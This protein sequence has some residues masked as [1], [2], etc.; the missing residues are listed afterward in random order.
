[1]ATTVVEKLPEFNSVHRMEI[2]LT[3]EGISEFNCILAKG[4]LDSAS[5]RISS[6]LVLHRP[7]KV[8]ARFILLAPS[9]DFLRNPYGACHSS[10]VLTNTTPTLTSPLILNLV[11]RNGLYP[12]AL[13]SD[14][15]SFK[16]K[17]YDM[18]LEFNSNSPWYF[19]KGRLKFK[20][21]DYDFEC[22]CDLISISCSRN[23]AGLGNLQ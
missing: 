4:C 20:P 9:C 23:D 13:F 10:G 11:T 18:N 17:E 7:I 3:C 21:T 6:I 5:E 22:K 2:N 14:S 12:Q 16:L 19:S 8:R 15:G 1:M